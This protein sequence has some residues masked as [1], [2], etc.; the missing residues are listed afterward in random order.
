MI[1]KA[2]NLSTSYDG[3]PILHHISFSIKKGEILCLLGPS[4]SGK[5]TL[6]RTLAGLEQPD[7]G[8]IFYDSD[9][10]TLVPPHKR[11]FGMMFQDYALFPHKNVAEN[12]DFGLKMQNLP[13]DVREQRVEEIL[14]LVGL[15]TYGGRKIAELSGGEQQRVALARSLAPRPRLLLLDEPLGALD[16][17][18]RD[19]LAVEIRTILK[20]LEMTAVFVTHDQT[21]AFSMADTIAVLLAGELAQ[22]DTPEKIYRS[23][24]N[25]EIARFLGFKNFISGETAEN[26]WRCAQKESS[27]QQFVAESTL[28]LRPEGAR[29]ATK[30]DKNPLVVEIIEKIY[31][32]AGYMITVRCL[33][34]KLHFTLPLEPTPPAVGEKTALILEKDALVVLPLAKPRTKT[35]P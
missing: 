18:L 8:T 12:I 15:K 1:L 9:D 11:Q 14:A 23:P 13:Q 29:L 32:G 21:E 22:F 35:H 20:E 34:E 30:Y 26:F 24:A 2:T 4:G 17:S 25:E 10:I 31:L 19:R 28:L 3:K 6:L 27:R 5:T 16:R 7:S 33:G